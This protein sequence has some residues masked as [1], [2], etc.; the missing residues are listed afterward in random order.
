MSATEI[1]DDGPR[2]EV[3]DHDTVPPANKG[4]LAVAGVLLLVPVVAL[5]WVGSYS[6]VEPRLWGFPFFIWYQFLWVFLCSAMTYTAYRIVLVARP[7]R[8]MTET[9]DERTEGR[10]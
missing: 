2:G 8:P 4:L 6:R 7:H 10:S 9:T 3:V 1:G 5:L